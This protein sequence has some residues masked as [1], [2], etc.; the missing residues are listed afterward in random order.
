LALLKRLHFLRSILS[1]LF[2]IIIIR[3]FYLQIIRHSFLLNKARIQQ[4]KFLKEP[5]ERGWIFD[6]RG[7][8]LG[9]IK[10]LYSIYANPRLI[11]NPDLTA[12][13]L[14]PILGIDKEILLSKLKRK[15]YYFV[16]LKRI[17]NQGIASKVKSLRINGIGIRIEPKR[18]YPNGK[19]ASHILGTVD[20]DNNGISG[21]ELEYDTLLKGKPGYRTV[22]IDG[23]TSI[24]KT[25]SNLYFP[26]KNGKHIILTI[27]EILQYLTEKEE[28]YLV[29]KYSPKRVSIVILDP[30]TGE[31]LALANSPTYD[32]NSVK[33]ED[34]DSMRNFAISD[35]FEPG[36]VLKMVTAS[37]LVEEKL[38]KLNEKI[39]CENGIYKMG[40]RIIRDWHPFKWLEFPAVIYNSSNIGVAKLSQ[41]IKPQ[42]FYEY[43]RKF[44]FG[45]K[46][47]V[48]LPGEVKGILREPNL[49]S[50]YSLTSIAMGQEIGVTTIQL[51]QAMAAIANDGLLITPHIVKEIRDEKGF[52]I[53]IISP[54][55]KRRVISKNTAEVIQKILIEVVEKGT[56][57]KA[58]LLNYIAGGKTGTAQ[59]FDFTQ[60]KYSRKRHTASFVGFVPYPEPKL[61]IAITVDEPTPIYYGGQVCAPVFK[62][63]ANAALS[64]LDINPEHKEGGELK[65][66]AKISSYKY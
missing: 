38:V 24:L 62:E 43:L 32:P 52:P 4:E 39:Y 34:V 22:I 21:I 36:S 35:V 59:K 10:N 47:G 14:A 54:K 53:K 63:I 66:V 9:S 12:S 26:P 37:V 25:E 48:D 17:V 23:R 3:L 16:W 30:N 57:K 8:I 20:I 64:Y 65:D 11:E 13:R 6:R 60:N 33:K 15:N 40:K 41:R 46:T 42:D 28:E 45:E 58:K 55:V 31:I 44:G 19:L 61:V 50:E 7:R 2:L 51:A 1:L 56:G 29:K 5:A 49:W 27:D 18:I